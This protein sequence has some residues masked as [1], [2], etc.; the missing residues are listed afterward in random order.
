M[1]AGVECTL[2]TIA[3][4][5]ERRRRLKFISLVDL[6][7]ARGRSRG[8]RSVLTLRCIA[9]DVGRDVVSAAVDLR[10]QGNAREA[11]LRFVV[12]DV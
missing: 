2:L 5:S 9:V 6:V 10:F 11:L 7:I 12:A 4:A 8:G 1:T 3:S